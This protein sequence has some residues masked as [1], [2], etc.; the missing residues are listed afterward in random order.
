MKLRIYGGVYIE[1]D[2]DWSDFLSLIL[3]H[4]PR[5]ANLTTLLTLMLSLSSF[6][7]TKMFLSLNYAW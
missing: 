1:W 3:W 2:I 5:L 7:S 4:F 6:S